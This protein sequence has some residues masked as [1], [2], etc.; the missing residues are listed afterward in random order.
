MKFYPY[1]DSGADVTL[2]PLSLGNLLGLRVDN[3]HVQKIGGISGSVSII[4]TK[5]NMRIGNSEFTSRIAWSLHEDVP[6]L[7]GRLD[8]FDQFDITFQ[9]EKKRI[10]FEEHG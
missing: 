4:Y 2:I 7:L 9:Q 5:R 3:H 8:V 6:P 1:I 10:V